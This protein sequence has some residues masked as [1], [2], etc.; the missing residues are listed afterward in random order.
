M[1]HIRQVQVQFTL[2]KAG[3]TSE[4]NEVSFFRFYRQFFLFCFYFIISLVSFVFRPGP[5]K[6]S[7]KPSATT[8]TKPQNSTVPN[9]IV[10]LIVNNLAADINDSAILEVVTQISANVSAAFKEITLMTTTNVPSMKTLL[11]DDLEM[12]A[13]GTMNETSKNVD[14]Y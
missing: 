4:L 6:K 7:S 1:E 12:K 5:V 13:S 10:Q 11:A 14:W 3:T 8:P 9:S 2:S